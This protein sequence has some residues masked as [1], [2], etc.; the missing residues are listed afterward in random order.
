MAKIA[1]LFPGQGSQVVGMGRELYDTSPGA[2]EVFERAGRVTGME[3]KELCFEGPMDK[4][5]QTANLQPCLTTVCLA[6][7]AALDE[8]GIKCGGAAGHSLGEYPALA[9]AGVLLPERAVALTAMR[10]DYME[11][12]AN[13]TPGAM[14]AVLGLE[15]EAV[16][17]AVAGVEGLVQVAN[18]NGATQIVITGEKEAVGRASEALKEAGAK[19]VIPLKVSGAWHSSLMSRA[20]ND[21]AV[22]LAQTD[23]RNAELPVYLNTSARPETQAGRIAELMVTQLTSPVRWYDI[24]NNMLAD[25][26]DTFVEI[27]PKNV[28]AGLVKKHAEGNEGIRI[29]GVDGPESLEALVKALG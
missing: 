7:L 27:G 24:M 20:A 1:F 17:E 11:R 22:R 25:G 13:A 6:V 2:R 18:H 21:F 5:T 28:L 16:A 4:L 23:W 12:D 15:M 19:R 14:A 9:C 29:F 8:A 10:G 3:I 26:F